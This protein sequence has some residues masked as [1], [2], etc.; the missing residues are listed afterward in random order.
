MSAYKHGDVG[1]RFEQVNPADARGRG[2]DDRQHAEQVPPPVDD[3]P[4]PEWMK[5]LDASAWHRR[6]V[7][8]DG[9]EPDPLTGLPMESDRELAER[10]RATMP[11]VT[12]AIIGD[13]RKPADGE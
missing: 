2:E 11:S 3:D 8:D 9:R 10:L 6:I 4:L 1:D 12:S 7:P 13:D 5:P